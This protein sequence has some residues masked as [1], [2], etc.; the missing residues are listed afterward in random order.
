MATRCEGVANH[1]DEHVV[2]RFEAQAF[3]ETAAKTAVGE[4]HVVS[5]AERSKSAR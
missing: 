3:W 1:E 4:V 2:V 5:H